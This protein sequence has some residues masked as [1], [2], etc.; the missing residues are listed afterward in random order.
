MPECERRIGYAFRAE[1]DTE[2]ETGAD[3]TETESR[4]GGGGGVAAIPIGVLE[5]GRFRS[6]VIP[7][8]SRRRLVAAFVV[9]AAVGYWLHRRQM[10]D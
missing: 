7:F 10:A 6:R 2:T 9:G 8:R 5:I 3:E 4:T 1:E